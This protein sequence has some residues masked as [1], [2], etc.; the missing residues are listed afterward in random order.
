[1]RLIQANIQQEL[2]EDYLIETLNLNNKTILELG[3]GTAS[4][5]INI[6]TNGF[7]RKIIACEVD[8]IQHEKNLQK[9]YE[10]IEFKLCG[11]EDIHLEDASV[12]MVFMFKSFHHV[13]INLMTKALSE[14][15]RVLKPNGLAY[16]SE[17][18]FTGE[19]SDMIAMFHNEEIVRVEAFNAIKKVVDNEEFKLFQ[20]VFFYSLVTYK[21][22]DEFKSKHMS[23]TFNNYNISTEL[24]KEVE[25]KFNQYAQKNNPIT[26]EKPFRVDILQKI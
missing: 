4:K 1:M 2:N 24:E 11:A 18:L 14:I 5:T 22:F 15:K 23:A 3:C 7:D 9:T 16:I 6:A 25:E 13:P 20:E 19:L 10:N 21:D 26:F 8:K 17:P 12:D